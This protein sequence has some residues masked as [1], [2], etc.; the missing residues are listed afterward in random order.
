MQ[1]LLFSHQQSA[2]VEILMKET[3]KIVVLLYDK[4]SSH[5]SVNEYKEKHFIKTWFLLPTKAATEVSTKLTSARNKTWFSNL[6][7]LT[8][9]L[10]MAP[11]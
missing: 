8:Q 1:V 4:S 2:E 6:F 11:K 9:R 3:E 7:Y 5:D 10:G